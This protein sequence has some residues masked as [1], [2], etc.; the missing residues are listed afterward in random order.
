MNPNLFS[1]L[2]LIL[3]PILIWWPTA[4]AASVSDSLQFVTTSPDFI[5]INDSDAIALDL[6]Y[7]TTNNF[8]GKN[9]Y[10]VFSRAFLHKIA[11][12]KL[13]RA[14]AK[15]KAIQPKYK[16]I[17]FDALRPRSVQYLLWDKVKGTKQQRYVANPQSGSIHN[18]GF[19]LDLSILDET[20]KE[21]DM[22]TPFDDFTTLAQPAQE[23]QFLESGRLTQQQLQ[24]R[25]LLRKVMEDAGFIQL[26]LE[27]WHFDALPK[28][29]VKKNYSIVE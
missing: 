19:A 13:A 9:L 28:I 26:P 29:E 7:A 14:A 24:N 23:E 4:Y 8:T 10:G 2:S 5:E 25:R 3:I 20:G 11:A 12:D 6:R 22:G 21:L 27:W 17:V 18:F 16:L 15:L 1:R